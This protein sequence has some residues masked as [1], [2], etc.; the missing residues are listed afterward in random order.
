MAYKVFL[1]PGH[2]GADS[3]AYDG[4]GGKDLLTTSEDNLNLQVA[5]LTAEALKRSGVMVKLS[6]TKDVLPS[7]AQ[8]CVMA[9]GWKANAFV[10]IH[11]N[12][13][14]S[15][16]RGIEGIY[17]NTN[18]TRAAKGKKMATL[19]YNRLSPLT[20]WPD[21]GVY[22]DVRGL[23]VLRG[24]KM[25]ACLMEYGFITNTEEEKL[26][27]SLG[28]KRQAAE[29]TAEGICAFLGVKYRPPVAPTPVRPVAPVAAKPKPVHYKLSAL[30]NMNELDEYVALSKKL[31]N[32]TYVEP[33]WNNTVGFTGKKVV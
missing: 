7:L 25:P 11:F 28:F 22:K 1:D 12:A 19:I 9:N 15:A 20:P 29:K 8:R 13:G 33:H 3:G 23:A 4:K 18:D 16:A 6:R 27:N 17:P 31:G 24:T 5:M 14:S 10:S 2:G 26:V 21:R 32:P 30:I